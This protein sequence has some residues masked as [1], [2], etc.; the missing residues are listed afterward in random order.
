MKSIDVEGLPEPVAQALASMA[1]VLRHQLTAPEHRESRA[2]VDLPLW[3]GTVKGG[4][5]RE[6]IYEHVV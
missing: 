5:T 3:P 2:P 1:D 4:L 6:E